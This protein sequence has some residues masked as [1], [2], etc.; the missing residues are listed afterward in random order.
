MIKYTQEEILTRDRTEDAEELLGEE[1]YYSLR[2]K[3]C[4]ARARRNSPK[5]VA[6]LLEIQIHRSGSPYLIQDCCGH[7]MRFPF[8]APK[9]R[10]KPEYI[11][12]DSK[13]EFIDAY[14]RV[15]I[16]E[17][18]EEEERYLN[19]HGMWLKTLAEDRYCMI[20]YIMDAGVYFAN[21]E[22]S[23][24]SWENLLNNFMFLG[25]TPCGKR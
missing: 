7:V 17:L 13:E 10:G 5:D 16:S 25:D 12:Y 3:D 1:V 21:D 14:A 23:L 20:K 24:W 2:L 8:I 22:E 6:R 19:E 4:L 18:K 11:P 9:K 15:R